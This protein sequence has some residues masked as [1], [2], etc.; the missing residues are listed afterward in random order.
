MN[1]DRVRERLLRFGAEALSASELLGVLLGASG[2]GGVVGEPDPE[3]PSR[4]AE[5]GG[6]VDLARRLFDTFGG[7]RGTATRTV[8]ELSQVEGVGLG[9]AA[10]VHAAFGLVR[11]FSEEALLRGAPIASSAA[12]FDRFH[13]VLRD[14]KRECFITILLDGKN[15]V[16]REDLV[17]VGSLT[18]SIVHPR[19]V[20][21]TAIRESADAVIFV[22]NH[23]SGDPTPSVEDVEI[24]NRLVEVSRIVGIRVLDHIVVGDGCYT[25]FHEKGLIHGQ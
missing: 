19:E 11:A 18:S 14:R 3:A 17:S 16:I 8:H 25:S 2:D 12:V 5:S 1:G 23:P 13:P 4:P 20:F 10:R 21:S 24:T 22:H 9:R 15:R 7:V 6:M